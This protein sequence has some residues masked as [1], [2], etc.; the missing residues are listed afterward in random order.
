MVFAY[1]L[2]LGLKLGSCLYHDLVNINLGIHKALFHCVFYFKTIYCII[3]YYPLFIY[4]KFAEHLTLWFVILWLY[5]VVYFW[6]MIITIN[7]YKVLHDFHHIKLGFYP[8][9]TL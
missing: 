9:L 1:Y 2:V 6:L 7:P 3:P 8:N 5:F 4:T